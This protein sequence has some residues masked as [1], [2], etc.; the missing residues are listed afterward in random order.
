VKVV[1]SGV[2]GL[3]RHPQYLGGFL[4]HLGVSLLLSS[5]DSLFVTPL[6]VCV[7]YLISWK[8]EVEL[9]NMFGDEYRD[10]QGKVPMLIPR[11]G[12]PDS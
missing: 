8:E 3:V 10:Y 12:A 1:S 11:L 7:V 4:G 2:Y 9:V 5:R 6:V